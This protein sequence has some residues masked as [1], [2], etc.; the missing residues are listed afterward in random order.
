MDD[1]P[2]PLPPASAET[3]RRPD[4]TVEQVKSYL[5]RLGVAVLMVSLAVNAVFTISMFGLRAKSKDDS[6]RQ[7]ALEADLKVALADVQ[8]WRSKK[9]V[10]LER[11]LTN[12]VLLGVETNYLL[13]LD[14]RF[15]RVA[16]PGGTNWRGVAE[17]YQRGCP[18]S[19]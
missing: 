3:P 6:R 14:R 1:T 8:F 11:V 2:Q 10:H 9:E 18:S 4:L 5:L 17:W 16:G 19:N 15:Q 7:A 13:D 12:Y